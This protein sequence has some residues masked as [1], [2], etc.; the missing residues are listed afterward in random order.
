[1]QVLVI[2][3]EQAVFD[4]PADGLVVPAYDGLVGILPGHA[5]FVTVLG[6]GRLKLRQNGEI[7]HYHVSGGILQV[8][9]GVVRVVA[10]SVTSS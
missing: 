9:A 2:S 5:P 7:R 4:G 8:A 3:P 10:D 6:E 1:M